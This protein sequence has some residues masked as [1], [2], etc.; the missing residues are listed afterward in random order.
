MEESLYIPKTRTLE[1]SQDY[2]FL[3]TEGFKYIEQLASKLW[4]DYNSHDPGIT[5]LEALCYAI[6]ELGYRTSFDIKDLISDE[7]G[8]INTNQAF[9]TARE[10]LTTKPLTILDYRKILVDINNV[11]NAHIF[12]YRDEECNLVGEPD[13]EVPIYAHCKKD[14][15]VYE[16]TNHSVKLHGLY[17]VILDLAETDEFGDLNTGNITWQFYTEELLNI[18]FQIL[19]PNWDEID[20]DFVNTADPSTITNPNISFADNSWQVSFKVSAGTNVS[21]FT[22]SAYAMLKKNVTAIEPAVTA[23]LSNAGIL[24]DIFSLYLEKIKLILLTLSDAKYKLHDNRNLCEDFVKL[25]TICTNEIAFCADIEVR[26]DADIEE[27]YAN[28]IFQVENYL[29][30]EVKFYSLKKLLDEGISADLIF[31]GPVLEHGFIK[32]DELA[33]TVPRTKIYVSDI[34]NFIMD[35]EGV[36]NVKNVLL[37]RY[38]ENGKALLPSQRWCLKIN[39]QCKP[40]LNVYKSKVLFFKGKLPFKVN[41]DETS[42]TLKY[43]HGIEERNKLKG[44]DSDLRIPRAQDRHL[45]DYASVQ[46]EFPVTY[47]VGNA[48]LPLNATQQRRA[49]SKQLKAYLLFYDQLLGNFFTQLSN[50][51]ELFS[52]DKN[53]RQ[54]YFAKYLNDKKPFSEIFANAAN[55]ELIL[56]APQPGEAAEITQ[57]RTKLFETPD[58]F[59]DRRNRFLDHLIA[60]FAESFNEYVFMLYTYKN[61]DEYEEIDADELLEDKIDFLKDYPSI[62]AERGKAFNY[63]EKSWIEEGLSEEEINERSKNVSGYVKR[64]SRLSGIDDFTT[65]FLFCIKN[66]EIQKTDSES[67]KYYFRVIDESGKILLQS[68]REYDAYKELDEVVQQI[69]AHITNSELYLPSDISA[70]EFTFELHDAARIPLAKSGVIYPDAAARNVAIENTIAVFSKNCPAEGMHLVEHILLRPRFTAPVIEGV[71]PE[72]V[73]RLIDVCL[74]QD[75]QFCGEEDP[76]SFRMSLIIPYWYEW[77]KSIEFRKYFDEMARTE[78]PAH[79]MIKVCWVNNT[80]MGEFERAFFEWLVALTQYEKD[81]K[82]KEINKDRFRIASNNLVE[83][84]QKLH[85]EYPEAQLHDCDTGVTNPVL[86]GSTILGTYKK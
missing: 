4:T 6:T 24:S 8:N 56:S 72:D 48:E 14:K 35:T 38:D 40:V 79:C 23:Q 28:I 43:L 12:P 59:Y 2:Y 16:R 3:R 10:I 69:Q 37:T 7:G 73:Y 54:T 55:L 52:L 36:M 27:V 82:Q 46:Y 74:G 19:F 80:L 26:P 77:F 58:L 83:I 75:C 25:E 11:K 31:E 44:A 60:R 21:S 81:L 62:S 20:H 1:K 70:T 45:S 32:T 57:A 76:Y 41:P 68:L 86:L 34:I 53:I 17:N 39:E 64:I 61:A 49:E 50:A 29:N 30:P 78:A 71:V 67:P 15:L 84:L 47:G 22:L 5:M 65:R 33:V 9:F 66:I 42:D 13:Q 18:K 63:L 51:K 85:S